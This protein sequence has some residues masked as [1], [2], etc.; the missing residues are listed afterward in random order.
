MGVVYEAEDLER[1]EPVA[2]KT[3]HAG[4]PPD[5][6]AAEHMERELRVGRGIRHRNVIAVLDGGR[7]DGRPFVVMERAAGRTL[8]CAIAEDRPPVAR[9]VAIVDQILAGLDAVHRAGYLHGDVKSDNILVAPSDHGTD[10]VKIIDFG[11]AHERGTN[12]PVI[13]GQRIF[14]GTPDYLAPEVVRGEAK[15][16]ASEVYGV[17]VILYELLTGATPFGGGPL[18]EILRRQVED[19]VIP[20]SL[21]APELRVSLSLERVV[22]RALAKQPEA[23]YPDAEAFRAAL[24]AA[25][26]PSMIDV[27]VVAR[28]FSTSARTLDWTRP[29]RPAALV[30]DTRPPVPASYVREPLVIVQTALDVAGAHVAE[31]HLAAARCELEAA[32]VLVEDAPVGDVGIWRLLLALAA[33]C[34]GL[35]EPR[36]ARDAARMALDSAV[37]VHSEIGR[38]RAKALIER[39]AGRSCAAL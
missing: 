14:S 10:I 17:G 35:N 4:H 19:E 37:R 28:P 5:G 25:T 2:I 31:H 9:V 20:P 6:I 18:D 29:E 22:L 30:V 15:T 36:R 7:D 39:F 32:L 34:D 3:L 1:T 26:Q 38:H 12:P 24:L 8:G 16:V 27:P 11:L 23:R 21:R 13:A 33:V